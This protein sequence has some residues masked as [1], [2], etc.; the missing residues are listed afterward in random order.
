MVT[1]TRTLAKTEVLLC[2]V[3]GVLFRPYYTDGVCPVCMWAPP[4]AAIESPWWQRLDPVL[5]AFAATLGVSVIMVM[6]VLVVF[7]NN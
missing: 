4:G 6:V 7:L 5:T 2:P 1:E 3:D